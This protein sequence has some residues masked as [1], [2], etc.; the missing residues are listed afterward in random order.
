MYKSSQ[1]H[2]I[3]HFLSKNIKSKSIL[4]LPSH[5]FLCQHP[6][7]QKKNI[8]EP[9]YHFFLYLLYM[10]RYDIYIS[11]V[12]VGSARAAPCHLCY[13]SSDSVN[14]KAK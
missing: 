1:S 6:K 13:L 11:N 7:T 9:V 3:P 4:V 2:T 10:N 8:Q 5:H 12:C 14:G